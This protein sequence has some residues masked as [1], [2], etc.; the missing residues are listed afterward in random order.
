MSS[1][2][3]IDTGTAQAG[4]DMTAVKTAGNEY[5]LV[6][7]GGANVLPLYQAPHYVE[8][9]DAARRE[10][11]Y[12]GHYF[13]SG[14]VPVG[15]AARY[16][17]GILHD[18]RE[19]DLLILDSEAYPGDGNGQLWGDGKCALF[20][21][22]VR[23]LKNAASASTVLYGSS[24]STFRAQGAWPQVKAIGATIWAAAYPGPPDM[25]GT[26]LTA[27]IHQFTDAYRVGDIRCD[28]NVSSVPAATLFARGQAAPKP[29]VTTVPKTTTAITGNPG[30]AGS[31]C[32]KRVQLLARHGG[33]RGPVD[34][35]LGILSWEGVQTILQAYGY[36]GPIDGEPG[37]ETWK[38]LQRLAQKRGAYTG[39]IDGDLGRQSWRGVAR[40]LN[41][42]PG[43]P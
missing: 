10:G 38:A 41:T 14:A 3:G 5:V 21:S 27:T 11:L 20:L 36:R 7:A 16:F 39:P 17:A 23:G 32:W 13:N 22:T 19:G 37:H 12:V 8:Q 24:G 9:V 30:P 26:G 35:H 34:G 43:T 40:Y 42:L 6:K 28:R 18:Y 4:I 1:S 31:A 29:A 25:T 15:D 33:Y 2:Y